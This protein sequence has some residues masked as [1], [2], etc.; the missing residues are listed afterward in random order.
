MM[1]TIL[2][3]RTTRPTWQWVSCSLLASL[4]YTH[5]SHFTSAQVSL[6]HSDPKPFQ[7]PQTFLR[8]KNLQ[9]SLRLHTFPFRCELS[10]LLE[11]ASK[12]S[13]LPTTS[14]STSRSTLIGKLS[15]H[16]TVPKTFLLK[17]KKPAQPE[18]TT[19]LPSGKPNMWHNT[20]IGQIVTSNYGY[21]RGLS[22]TPLCVLR[23]NILKC[24][25][26]LMKKIYNI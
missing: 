18:L 20:S 25:R 15:M 19:P 5:L 2:K 1:H 13:I 11:T 22:L 21:L 6:N 26:P 24:S 3:T 8:A 14:T 10:N 7:V 9:T 16:T 17:L 4:L 23:S 12:G